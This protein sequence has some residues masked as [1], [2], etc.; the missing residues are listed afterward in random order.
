MVGEFSVPNCVM[1]GNRTWKRGLALAS[2]GYNGTTMNERKML[3]KKTLATE[4]AKV[5]FGVNRDD[6]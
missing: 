6:Y 4:E 5:T 1:F 2:D 3:C